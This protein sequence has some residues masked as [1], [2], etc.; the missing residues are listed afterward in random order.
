MFDWGLYQISKIRAKPNW[1]QQYDVEW[2]NKMWT[3]FEE[4]KNGPTSD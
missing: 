2:L 4:V 1:Q 3:L